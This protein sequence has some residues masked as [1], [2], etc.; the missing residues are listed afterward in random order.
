MRRFVKKWR[1]L[2]CLIALAGM[3]VAPYQAKAATVTL[4]SDALSDSRPTVLANHDIKF[5]MDSGTTVANTEHA[6]IKFTGFTVGSATLVQADFAVK[7]DA[8]GAGSYTAL[9]PTTDFTI[10][11]VGAGAD[12]VVV[13]TFTAA[14]ATAISTNKYMEV[15][16]TNGADKLP[17]PAAGSYTVDIDQSNFGDTGQ[18]Q[19]AVIAGVTTTATVTASL[20]VTVAAVADTLT[21]NGQDLDVTSTSSTVPFSTLTVNTFKA[22]AHDL[23]VSTNA[24]GGYTTSVRQID[25][26]GMTN[27]LASGGTNNIDGFRGAG[28]TATNAAPLAW[29]AGTNPTGTSANVNTGW[30]GYT[31][32][33]AVLGTGTVDRFTST[34]NFWAPFDTTA[35]EVAYDNAPVNAQIIRVGHMIETNALQ[36]QGVYTGVV[37]YIT[38][39][40]F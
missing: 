4:F 21:V 36:P 26:S 1:F 19:V 16:F 9:T 24:A 34:P 38:T 30:Y 6:D 10:A 17:N 23:T 35:Y 8:D 12:P 40:V 15:V 20:S 7:H 11:T 13:V 27:V 3:F 2:F 18:V 31:T 37:E 39:A 25:G 14:G 5:K 33:D 22:A 29:A 28:G 32:E